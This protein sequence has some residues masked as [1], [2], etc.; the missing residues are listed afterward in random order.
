MKLSE[1]YIQKLDEEIKGEQGI[2]IEEI[3]L[4]GKIC[5]LEANKTFLIDNQT[6]ILQEKYISELSDIVNTLQEIAEKEGL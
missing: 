3:Q 6:I 1:K 2:V 4:Y 5:T